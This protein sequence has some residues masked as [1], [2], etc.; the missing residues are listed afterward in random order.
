MKITLAET[1]GFCFGVDRAVKTLE[2]RAG[3]EPISTLGPIIHNEF[4]VEDLRSKGVDTVGDVSE[5]SCDTTLAIRTHGVGKDVID[6]LEDKGI[7]YIDLT[8]P[9]VKK[10]HN[11]VYKHYNCRQQKSP[12][13]ARY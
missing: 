11:I 7:R 6:T 2:S 3:Q 8:C 5:V 4:V 13:S 1:A 9:F 10:I 12:R